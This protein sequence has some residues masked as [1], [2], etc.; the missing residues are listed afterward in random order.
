M[1]NVSFFRFFMP[2][3]AGVRKCEKSEN[4]RKIVEMIFDLCYTCA[5]QISPAVFADEITG[6]G[7]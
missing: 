5:K 6:K 3:P 2:M 7:V 1:R 4:A